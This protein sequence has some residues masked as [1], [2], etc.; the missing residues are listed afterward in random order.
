MKGPIPQKIVQTLEIF[1]EKPP[2]GLFYTVK[3]AEPAQNLPEA[4]KTIPIIRMSPENPCP[5]V[6]EGGYFSYQ[7]FRL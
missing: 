3:S 4:E 7:T 6:F 1:T 2:N 5:V